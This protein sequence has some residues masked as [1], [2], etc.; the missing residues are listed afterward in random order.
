MVALSTKGLKFQRWQVLLAA[1]VLLGITALA[2]SFVGAASLTA[3]QIFALRLPRILLAILV[4]ASLASSGT[5]LQALFRNPLA[6]PFILGISA[7]GALGRQQRCFSEHHL[8][9]YRSQPFSLPWGHL[10][11]FTGSVVSTVS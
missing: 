1:A 11:S 8:L 9:R 7:G 6:D 3:E 5:C 2:A 4:G 10:G